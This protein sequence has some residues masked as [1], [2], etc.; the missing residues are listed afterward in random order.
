MRGFGRR[1]WRTLAGII[2]FCIVLV[3]SCQQIDPDGGQV[4]SVGDRIRLGTTAQIVTLDPAD[5]YEQSSML[6]IANLGETLYRYELDEQGDL[7][8]VPTLATELPRLSDDELTY[9]IPLREDVVFHDGTP[10]NAEAMAF[11]LRR[12]R[13]NK[14]RASFLLGD[15]LGDIEATGEYELTLTLNYPFAGFSALLTFPGLCAIS[16]AAYEIGEGKFFPSQFV[17]TGPYR[18]GTYG[19]DSVGFE[20]FQ[21]Y[22]GDRPQNQGIDM[23]RFSSQA[24]LYN[25]FRTGG[26]DVA[27][28]QLDPDQIRSLQERAPEAGF[29]VVEA[30]STTISYLVLNINQPPFDRLEVR[31]ALA[32]IMDRPL[33]NERVFYDQAEPLYSLIPPAFE[34]HRPLFLDRYGDGNVEKA[35][36]LLRE[37]G[38]SAERPLVVEMWFPSSSVPGRLSATILQALAE[39]DL[40]DLVT[41]EPRS[42]EAATAYGYLDKGVYPTFLLSWYADFFDADNYV[43]P[44]LEC[45]EGS[46]E[47]GCR[48]GETQY[49]GSFFYDSRANELLQAQRQASDPQ[50]RDRLL[51]ELQEIVVEQVPYI[52]LWQNKDYAFAQADISGVT[53]SKTQQVL[54]FAS[55]GR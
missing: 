48:L 47:S 35:K 9:T 41:I 24:N 34:S 26:V 51:V 31:Q 49:H 8:L 53:L 14:G 12:F 4:N 22:W 11:S 19:S 54:P 50:V 43:K 21:D 30:E 46:P 32:A 44:F 38:F 18:L 40:E 6:A 29:Q 20:I 42:V 2:S 1:R 39:R 36:G 15:L 23:R 33:L 55:I 28:Q 37:A 5:A 13:D 3:V 17:G 27:Y 52:P 16:P 45:Q 7:T 25:A 10:F